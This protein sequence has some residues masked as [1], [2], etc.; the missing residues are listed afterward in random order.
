MGNG[1]VGRVNLGRKKELGSRKRVTCKGIK[2]PNIM[3]TSIRDYEF[4][5]IHFLY[6][7][8]GGS[9]PSCGQ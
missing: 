7:C 1:E 4:I 2:K 8:R 5:K 9:K 3:Q 6:G